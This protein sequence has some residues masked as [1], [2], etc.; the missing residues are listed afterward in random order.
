M[1]AEAEWDEFEQRLARLLSRL[2]EETYLVFRASD[3][4]WVQFSQG[5][6]DL[7]AEVVGNEYLAPAWQLDDAAAAAMTAVGWELDLFKTKNWGRTLAWPATSAQYAGLARAGVSAL[8]E[9]LQVAQPADVSLEWWTFSDSDVD[10]AGLGVGFAPMDEKVAL[11]NV[12]R[13]IRDNEYDDYAVDDLVAERFDVGWR[14]FARFPEVRSPNDIVVGRKI[15]LIGD[16]GRIMESS[17][18]FPP[19]EQVRRFVETQTS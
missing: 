5:S 17:S 4:R 16:N 10:V 14:V 1:T 9:S 18:S 15:F 8:R 19:K 6:A 11:Q 7:V 2:P 13:H 3:N 12:R